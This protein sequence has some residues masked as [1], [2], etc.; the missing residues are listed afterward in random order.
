MNEDSKIQRSLKEHGG[1]IMCVVSHPLE[2]SSL[3]TC[4]ID[5]TARLWNI[6]NETSRTID[7][8]DGLV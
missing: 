4:S 5:G 6:L 1:W 3:A 7:P 2:S 8:A